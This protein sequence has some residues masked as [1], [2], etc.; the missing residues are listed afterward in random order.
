MKAALPSLVAVLTLSACSSSP[1]PAQNPSVLVSTERVTTGSLPATVTGFGRTTPTASGAST[2]SVAQPGQIA[3]LGV[4]LGTAVHTGQ[5][6]VMF[7]TAPSARSTYQ[8]AVNALAAARK[9]RATTAQLLSQQLAT[10]DQLTQA[11]KVVTDAAAALT[12]LQAE[13]AGYASR[14]VTAPFDGVVTA[15]SVAPGDRVPAGAPL[16]TVARL[17]DLV[18]TVGINPAERSRLRV[19]ETA[20]LHR[21]ATAQT[22]AGRVARVDAA[23]NATTRMIDIDLS[24][25]TGL[26]LPGEAVQADIEVGRV[27]GWIVPHRAVVTSNGP[28]RLFQVVRGRA[29]AVPVTVALSSTATDVVQGPLDPAQ[30]LIVD[31]AYQVSDGD[32]VRT[33]GR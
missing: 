1:P 15:V 18:V 2:L 17:R 23:L 10:R 9:Q 22:I 24:F 14:M 3:K 27:S 30:A 8:Q 31:G 25:P 21:L 12:A 19:G 26:L 7:A 6:L 5:P 33:A 16:I 28:P 29:K 20:T 32:A 11:D 4:T 13:G